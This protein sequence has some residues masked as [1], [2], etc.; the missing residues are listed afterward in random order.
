[1]LV[2]AIV[3]VANS[4]GSPNTAVGVDVSIFIDGVQQ[5]PFVKVWAQ[6]SSNFVGLWTTG[7]ITFAYTLTPGLHTIEVRTGN[8]SAA[9]NTVAGPSATSY[10]GSQLTVSII[11]L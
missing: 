3:Y 1:V 7:N 11:K 5:P 2:D 10:L 4:L 8:A 6:N 9:G